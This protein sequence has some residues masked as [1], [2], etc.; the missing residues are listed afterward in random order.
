MPDAVVQNC[1]V[2]PD[3]EEAC[4]RFHALYGI[5]PFVGG[6]EVQL[7]EHYHRGRP[8][9]PV[10]LRGVFVQSGDLNI[11]LVQLLS[12]GPSAFRDMFAPGEGGF[13][14][15][16]IFCQDYAGT[17]DRLVEQGCPVASSFTLSFGPEVC[18]VDARPSLGHMIE[19]Y[20]EDARI[21]ALYAEARDA[22]ANWDG[23]DLIVPR[24]G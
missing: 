13:H 19:L 18:Y 8:V 14:H 2:V 20:P 5:G 24:Q 7:S 22:A 3:L 17:R 10:R 1:Y 6:A 11:E 4:A 15:V 21:R 9:E 12:D 23:R 16:A